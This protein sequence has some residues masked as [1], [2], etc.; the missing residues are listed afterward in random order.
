MTS[1]Y[2]FFNQ[3]FGVVFAP[4]VQKAIEKII[5]L[6]AALGFLIHLGLIFLKSQGIVIFS[7]LYPELL[8]DPISAIY[9]PF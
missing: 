8:N 3:L 7:P 4:K 9:T 1:F 5:L 6:L 2:S